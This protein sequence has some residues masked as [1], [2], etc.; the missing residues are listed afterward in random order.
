[1][2]FLDDGGWGSIGFSWRSNVINWANGQ[3]MYE[4]FD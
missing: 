4:V 2:G 3:L 1:M